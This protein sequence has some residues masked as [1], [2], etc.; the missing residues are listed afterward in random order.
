MRP[1]D[2]SLLLDQHHLPTPALAISTAARMPAI[3]PPITI[4]RR[5]TLTAIDSGVGYGLPAARHRAEILIAFSV[6]FG[7]VLMNP[8]H[9]CSRILAISQVKIDA[10]PLWHYRGRFFHEG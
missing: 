6:P 1:P 8:G 7:F 2:G 5:V 10:G 4:A 9:H 3:P